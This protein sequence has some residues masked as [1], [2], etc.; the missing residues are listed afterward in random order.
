MFHDLDTLPRGV[1][2]W[3]G[4]LANG[5]AGLGYVTVALIFLAGD[6]G[7][8]DAVLPLGR[9]SDTLGKVL[10]APSTSRAGC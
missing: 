8:G 7:G 6:A 9:V 1:N 4:A 3:R 5:W 2:L 10:R